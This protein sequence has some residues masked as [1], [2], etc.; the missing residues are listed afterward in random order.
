MDLQKIN[1]KIYLEKGEDIPLKTFI[2]LFH[3]YI[4][5]NL[6]EGLL[7]DV[8][9]YTHVHQG[10][11]VLLIA[12]E[13]NYS[14]DETD[15]KRGLLYNSKRLKVSDGAECLKTAFRRALKACE[16][17]EKEP[18]LNGKLKFDPSR[19]RLFINDRLGTSGKNRGFSEFEETIR[20]FL[21][22]LTGSAVKLIPEMD[23]RKLTAYEVE[24]EKPLTVQDLIQKL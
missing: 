2:P 21:E 17:L 10:P 15:G 1:V 8:A 19:L 20:P 22:P 13:G 9:E 3:R 24:I 12:H 6:L 5:Q 14:L 16:L 18:E 7:V 23:P 11:G 4:Q